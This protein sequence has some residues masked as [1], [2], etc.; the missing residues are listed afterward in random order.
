MDEY[1]LTEFSIFYKR[2]MRIETYLN[3]NIHSIMGKMLI[4][5][6]SDILKQSSQKGMI[7]TKHLT[8]YIIAT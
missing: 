4:T 3:K 8:K 1:L 7:K 5:L 6:Y 2:I